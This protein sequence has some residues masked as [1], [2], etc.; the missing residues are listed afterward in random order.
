[1]QGDLYQTNRKVLKSSDLPTN[2][3]FSYIHDNYG[4]CTIAVTI[5]LLKNTNLTLLKFIFATSGIILK[6]N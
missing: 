5:S 6:S 2:F 1:M 4:S 3:K